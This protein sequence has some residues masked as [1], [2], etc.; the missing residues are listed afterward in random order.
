MALEIW[1]AGPYSAWRGK[2]QVLESLHPA[3]KKFNWGIRI[4]EGES[5][6]PAKVAWIQNVQKHI[7]KH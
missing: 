3:D 6:H 4:G 5:S 2:S 1:R 7:L